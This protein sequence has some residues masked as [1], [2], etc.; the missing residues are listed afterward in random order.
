[1]LPDQSL[2]T[3]DDANRGDPG[4]VEHQLPVDRH[5]RFLRAGQP[6]IAYPCSE[7]R[8]NNTPLTLVPMPGKPS[9]R[10]GVILEVVLQDVLENHGM[11]GIA[12]V[13]R[14]LDVIGNHRFDPL[15]AGFRMNKVVAQFKG[16]HFRYVLVL[17]NGENFFLSQFGQ[18]DAVL[19]RQHDSPFLTCITQ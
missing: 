9:G 14:M 12:S 15:F 10:A 8:K 18:F 6:A 4:L 13:L 5:R 16:H 1:M 19:Q 3:W 2:R 7:L 17:R 11:F